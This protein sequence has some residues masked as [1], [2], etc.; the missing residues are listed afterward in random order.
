MLRVVDDGLDSVA[1][2]A[3]CSSSSAL[4][5]W[6]WPSVSFRWGLQDLLLLLLLL[7]LVDASLIT[8]AADS[9][10]GGADTVCFVITAHSSCLA[11]FREFGLA[12]W[13]IW[14]A[15]PVPRD[16]NDSF[17]SIGRTS[18]P[19]TRSTTIGR[20]WMIPWRQPR[21]PIKLIQLRRDGQ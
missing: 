16:S 18:W 17:S 3:T 4:L 12:W 11:L 1:V 21:K 19:D 8:L 10:G 2:V 13:D 9:G 7:L 14:T 5:K 20:A 6:A 15:V